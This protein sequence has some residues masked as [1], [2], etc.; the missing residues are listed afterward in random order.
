MLHYEKSLQLTQTLALVVEKSAWKGQSDNVAA[1]WKARLK[2]NGV[3]I[4]EKREP[5]HMD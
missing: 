1:I 4:L 3:A 2:K 5:Q